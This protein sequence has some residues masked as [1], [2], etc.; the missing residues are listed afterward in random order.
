MHFCLVLTI[1][2][3]NYLKLSKEVDDIVYEIEAQLIILKEGEINTGGNPSAE[4]QEEA[5]ADGAQQVNNVVHSHRLQATTFDKKSYLT[6]L[7]VRICLYVPDCLPIW[8]RD[9]KDY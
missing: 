2:L 3:L 1:I 8:S 4:E 6:Y 9:G 7:K 5:L